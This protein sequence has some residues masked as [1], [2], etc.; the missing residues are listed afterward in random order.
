MFPAIRLVRPSY[1]Y[2]CCQFLPS[3]YEQ[4]VPFAEISP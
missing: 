4:Q 1:A 2:H 3:T